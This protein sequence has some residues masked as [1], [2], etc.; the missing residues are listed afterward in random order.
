MRDS[1]YWML[2]AGCA[3]RVAG[4]G[5]MGIGQRAWCIEQGDLRPDYLS[6][7]L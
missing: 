5:F 4:C 1:G 6:S 2:D 3:V 7:V